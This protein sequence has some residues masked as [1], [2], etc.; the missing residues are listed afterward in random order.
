LATGATVPALRE[1]GKWRYSPFVGP[2][3]GSN[4]QC[5]RP[6]RGCQDHRMPDSA[7]TA[8][9]F[10][11]DGV[12]VDSRGAITGCINH[13]LAARGLPERPQGDLQ[14]FIGPPLAV[15][16]A[17]LTSEPVESDLV[18]ACVSAYRGRY[19]D[20]SLRETEVFDGIREVLRQLADDH[21]LAVATSKPRA[22]AEPILE[23]LGLR[24]HFEVVAGPDLG[25]LAE[26]KAAT[27][28]SALDALGPVRAV[29]VGDRSFDIRG[30]HAHGLAAIGVAWGIGGADELTAAGADVVVASPAGLPAA[31]GALLSR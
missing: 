17:E 4:R 9:L 26:T 15:A 1:A 12:L 24:E 30:A 19:A 18:A 20:V 21:R 27:I 3:P 29:M 22:M 8:V 2:V 31:I 25:A 28:R 11:L 14:R 6:H 16:F 7:Q 10:D 13:A 5:R 23:V